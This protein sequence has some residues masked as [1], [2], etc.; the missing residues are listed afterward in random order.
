[1]QI[2]KPG[3]C[4]P[5]TAIFLHK[6]DNYCINISYI[7]LMKKMIPTL[8]P[9]LFALSITHQSMA[10]PLGFFT[11]HTQDWNFIQS[12]GGMTAVL[13]KDQLVVTCDVSGT[14]T[15]TIKPTMINSA[16][17]VRKLK[18]SRKGNTLQLTLITSVLEKGKKTTCD[19][20]DVSTYPP[21]TYS[22]VYRDPDGTTHTL[23]TIDLHPDSGP[24]EQAVTP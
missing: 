13:Q 10:G 23:N 19:P 24:A 14:Q 18:C 6:H 17:G 1:M 22:V 12:V 15:V 9:V 11:R 3:H 4:D 8:I 21:G 20:I 16:M 7:P 2:G 5:M